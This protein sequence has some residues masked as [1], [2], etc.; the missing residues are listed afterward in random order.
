MSV[1][2]RSAEHDEESLKLKT[3]NTIVCMEK[4]VILCEILP[5]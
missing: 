1:I 3:V 4:G 5:C 2:L